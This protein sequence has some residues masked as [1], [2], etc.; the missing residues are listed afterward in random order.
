MATRNLTK[1]LID[2]RNAAKANR[3][4]RVRDDTGSEESDSG[5]LRVT[6]APSCV[7]QTL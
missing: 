3:T 4:L 2:I 1:K 6:A 7:R 5:L